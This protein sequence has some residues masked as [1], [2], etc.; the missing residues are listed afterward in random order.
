M[1]TPYIRGEEVFSGHE[2]HFSPV[3]DIQWLT[4]VIAL[5]K[6]LE[7]GYLKSLAIVKQ[8]CSECGFFGSCG[9]Y[10]VCCRCIGFVRFVVLCCAVLCPWLVVG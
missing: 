1:S 5:C 2:F 10:F 8:S 3:Y 6:R 4:T 7:E 9:W